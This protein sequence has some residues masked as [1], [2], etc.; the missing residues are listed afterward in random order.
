M[1]RLFAWLKTTEECWIDMEKDLKLYYSIKETAA[2]VGVPESTLRYWEKQFDELNPRKTPSGVRQYTKSDIELLK[3]ISHL[4]KDKGLTISGAKERLKSS[5]SVVVE[6]S[7]IVE[8]LKYVRDELKAML[9][10]MK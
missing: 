7:E 8:R 4:V 2:I 5:K 1:R 6:T 9:D 3:L 10:E